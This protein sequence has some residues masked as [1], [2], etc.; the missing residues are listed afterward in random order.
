MGNQEQSP[1]EVMAAVCR[2]RHGRIASH[3]Q[4]RRNSSTHGTPDYDK[5]GKQ[6]PIELEPVAAFTSLRP[7]K[8]P[9]AF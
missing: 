5:P 7:S 9:T 4:S 1:F 8:A 2:V 6:H 3:V